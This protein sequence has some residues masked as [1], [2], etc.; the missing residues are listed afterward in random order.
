MVTVSLRETTDDDFENLIRVRYGHRAIEPGSA[1]P[2]VVQLKEPWR[3]S[4]RVAIDGRP[5]AGYGVDVTKRFH[6][7]KWFGHMTGY[8]AWVREDG[9][10]EIV[11]PA[12]YEYS[13]T[14]WPRRLETPVGRYHS[15]EPLTMVG[16]NRF[17]APDI[18][19]RS[20]QLKPTQEFFRDL[21]AH[22][23]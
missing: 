10:Y 7:S 5:A 11:A 1:Q 23:V 18:I 9:S 4:G 14:V 22:N 6:D 12:D 8:S 17:R 19:I 13:V 16:P 21:N 20:S 15:Q 2:L 3:I